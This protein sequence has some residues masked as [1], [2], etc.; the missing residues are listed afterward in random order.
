MG[1]ISLETWDTSRL[2]EYG[3]GLAANRE[4]VQ[5]PSHIH[6]EDTFHIYAEISNKIHHATEHKLYK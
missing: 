3:N 6:H 4:T 1:D 5:D 2:P